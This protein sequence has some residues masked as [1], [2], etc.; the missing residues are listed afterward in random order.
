MFTRM[1]DYIR[2]SKKA[3]RTMLATRLQ[4][5]RCQRGGCTAAAPCSA[6]VSPHMQT[7]RHD[8]RR[9]AARPLTDDKAALTPYPSPCCRRPV[10]NPQRSSEACPPLPLRQYRWHSA[11]RN[12]CTPRVTPTV[13][14]LSSTF[15]P[16]TPRVTPT[17]SHLSST[18][19]H[20]ST[21]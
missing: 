13:S 14:H 10:P 12:P 21:W 15:A 17:V 5:R 8:V 4:S 2:G 7:A 3:E 16:C 18:F 19:A 9:P 11:A 1:R 6:A 20:T